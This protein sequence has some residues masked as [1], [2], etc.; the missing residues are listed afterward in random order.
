MASPPAGIA[1]ALS[2]LLAVLP[3]H[4][5]RRQLYL[6]V[7]LLERH[8][9][10][11]ADVFARRASPALNQ[12]AA[13]LRRL[14]RGHLAAAANN[15]RALPQQAVPA[16]L[17]I[18]PLRKS[19]DRLDRCDIFSPKALSPWARQWLIWRA[20]RNPDRLAG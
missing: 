20:A 16:F 6:P 19:L 1:Y 8:G 10:H 14:A 17:P 13:D 2:Q 3:G 11:A 18:A 5:V 12:A 4:A 7:E 9:A 15:L